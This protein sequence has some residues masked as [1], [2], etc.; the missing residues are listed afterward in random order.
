MLW[1]WAFSG[2]V[3]RVS[4]SICRNCTKFI[5]NALD[6][7]PE[8]SVAWFQFTQDRNDLEQDF[9]FFFLIYYNFHKF[10]DRFNKNYG[11]RDEK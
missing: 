5:L 9:N 2:S 8:R 10:S 6:K 7:V 1:R 4:P 3:M 11:F